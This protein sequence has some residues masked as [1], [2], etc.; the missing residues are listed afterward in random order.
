M[1]LTEKKVASAEIFEGKV[2][3]VTVDKVN[4]PNGAESIREI[5]HHKGAVCVIP[6]T[7]DG[8]VVCVKQ[9]RY[10]HGEVLL[11]IPAGKLEINDTD[12]EEAARR[13]LE[14]ETG[15]K[16]KE[17]KYLGKLYTSPAIF[18]EVIHMYLATGL[19]FGETHPDEDEF[20]ETERIPLETL[21]DMVMRGEIPDSKTQVCVLRAFLELNG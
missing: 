14:E 17:L 1:D 7:D 4:L 13:E 3:R 20:L 11:E 8:D 15:A 2:I 21:K 16:C 9:F 6:V 18:T 12:P 19:T 10:A 5:V